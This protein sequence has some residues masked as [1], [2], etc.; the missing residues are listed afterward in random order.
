MEVP[1]LLIARSRGYADAMLLTTKISVRCRSLQLSFGGR[2]EISEREIRTGSDDSSRVASL[3]KS[4]SAGVM[5]AQEKRK[6]RRMII[7]RMIADQSV[8]SSSS[9]RNRETMVRQDFR[10]RLASCDSM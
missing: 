8:Y 5:T 10:A 1:R 3:I 7:R 9:V 4:S 6:E 2:S